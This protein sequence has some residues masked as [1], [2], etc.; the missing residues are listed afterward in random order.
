MILCFWLVI[1]FLDGT[2]SQRSL[3]PQDAI[4]PGAIPSLQESVDEMTHTVAPVSEVT[5]M[6]SGVVHQSL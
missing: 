3:I 2:F 6:V 4:V 1:L 5:A